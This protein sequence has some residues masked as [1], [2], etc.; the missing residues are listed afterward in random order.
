M[1]LV[2]AAV[3]HVGAA[4]ALMQWRDEES[5]DDSLGSIALDLAPEQ[6]FAPLIEE[7]APP[8][9][10]AKRVKQVAEETPV[11]APSPLAPKPEVQV[12]VREKENPAITSIHGPEIPGDPISTALPPSE[13]KL[14]DI[15]TAPAPG[16]SASVTIAR[17]RNEL[18]SHI[19]RYKRWPAAD[20]G[21][22]MHGVVTLEFTVHRTG[23]IVVSRVLNSSGFAVLDDAAMS[24]LQRASPLPIP[25]PQASDA[26]LHFALPVNYRK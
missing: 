8:Q 11:V 15:P 19:D 1:A 10:E 26:T 9:E 17:W 5:Y 22:H 13:T 25:P 2:F 12:P 6:T 21:H 7:G 14:S 3:L 24:M 16:I 18:L 20:R 23:Q 4:L